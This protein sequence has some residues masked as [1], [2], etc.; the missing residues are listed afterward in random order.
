MSM[1][2][3]SNVLN[4]HPHVREELRQRVTTAVDKLGY[5]PLA[6]GRNLRSG[7]TG[8][9]MLAIP[10]FAQPYFAELAR[11]AVAVAE[12][13]GMSLIVQQTDDDLGRERRIVEGWNLGAVDGMLFSPSSISDEELER[14]HQGIPLVLL[15]EHSHLDDIDRVRIDSERIGTLAT[16]HL[17]AQGRR[18]IGMIGFKA[19]GDPHVVSE[20]HTGYLSALRE[21]G[22]EPVGEY[23]RVTD[24]T[25]QAG[26]AAMSD[27]LAEVPDIDAV[28]AANDL[29]AL[30]AMKALRR[31]GRRAP[32][33]VAVIGVDDIEEAQ[34]AEPS[35][36]T[37][38]I[39]R[40]TMVTA[41]FE[42]LLARIEDPDRPPQSRFAPV[43]LR[44]RE[45]TARNT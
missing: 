39:D 41:A 29:L 1:S 33:D 14:R 9:I 4:G 42:L 38:A 40:R 37:V 20:R 6:I 35:L 19:T 12:L 32:H 24:W 10:N 18:R 43:K 8:Q 16:H 26:E 22:L 31:H 21:H 30:G 44:V 7:S 23:A 36:S 45:S 15:G 3:V 27:L 25:R 13:A 34:F 2:S 17:I 5:R 11:D 28:F